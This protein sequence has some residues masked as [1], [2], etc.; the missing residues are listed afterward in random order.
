MRKYCV[1]ICL[2]VLQ[3]AATSFVPVSIRDQIESSD[4]I[5]Q[6]EVVAVSSERDPKRGIVSKV[7]IRA[8]RWLG[9]RVEQNHIELFYPGGT[10]GEEGV[11]VHGSPRFKP[12]EKVVVLSKR[13][14][15][16]WWVQN[17]GMGKF[18]L[19]KVGTGKVLVNQIFPN[20]PDVGQMPLDSFLLLARE[21]KDQKFKERFKDKYERT[22]EKRAAMVPK[23]K[24]KGSRSIASVGKKDGNGGQNPFWLALLLGALGAVVRAVKGRRGQ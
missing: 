14:N 6:G 9:A 7:F 22:A 19:K 10:L 2:L 3:A 17:L 1:F 18:A 21:I 5:V 13:H 15:G 24:A 8:D 12:G 4:G 23:K 16:K 20:T 11:K